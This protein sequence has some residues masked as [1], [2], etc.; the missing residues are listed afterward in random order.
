[1]SLKAICVGGPRDGQVIEHSALPSKVYVPR[2][3]PKSQWSANPSGG[4]D[5]MY[6]FEIN[7]FDEDGDVR[8]TAQYVFEEYLRVGA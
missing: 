5:A 3:D 1:M 8:Q 2:D 6:R 7:T 4:V